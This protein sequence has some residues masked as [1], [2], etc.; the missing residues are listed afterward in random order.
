MKTDLFF[1]GLQNFG[2]KYRGTRHNIGA[3][4]LRVFAENQGLSFKKDKFCK[5]E[6]AI[7]EYAGKIVTFFI[8]SS[9]MN[10]SGEYIK[11]AV[12]LFEFDNMNNFI[13]LHDEINVPIGQIKISIGKSSGGHNGVESVIKSMHTKKFYRIRLGIGKNATP[14][15]MESF[16]LKKFSILER[17]K[18]RYEYD[19]AEKVIMEIIKNGGDSAMNKFN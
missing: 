18:L 19:L 4:V 13:V 5:G 8:P 17:N 6:Y 3:D 12:K 1:T 2:E 11:N 7:F 14:Q 10:V 9:F 15:N 16:V